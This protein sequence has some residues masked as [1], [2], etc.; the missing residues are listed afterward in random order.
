MHFRRTLPLIQEEKARSVRGG[1][2][3]GHVADFQVVDKASEEQQ[4]TCRH[5]KHE[6]HCAALKRLKYH[7]NLIFV[8]RTKQQEY[9]PEPIL[10][11]EVSGE[12][13]RELN[14]EWSGY[15]S[16]NHTC[17]SVLKLH[18]VRTL[19]ISIHLI[20]ERPKPQMAP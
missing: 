18:V 3:L 17:A 15:K 9:P 14:T 13:V 7:E 20:R 19:T 6:K 10:T 2:V 16:F 12:V 1:H 11:V 5:E 8:L 4:Q